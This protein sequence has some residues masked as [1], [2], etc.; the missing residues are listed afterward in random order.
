LPLFEISDEA[1]DRFCTDL[2]SYL[3]EFHNVHRYGRRGD[4]QD[5]IDAAG[6]RGNQH[7]GLQYR[8][9]RRFGPQAFLDTVADTT[10]E[11]D[12]YILTLASQASR[13][14][15]KA[16][17]STPNWE[18][19]DADD[20]AREVRRLPNTASRR[21]LDTYFGADWRRAF[22]GLQGPGAFHT[23]EDHFSPMMREGLLFDHRA[24]LVGR[25]EVI[26]GIKGITGA[27]N[28]SIVVLPGRGG[29]GKSRVLKAAAEAIVEEGWTVLFADENT[30]FDSNSLD[31]LPP[32]PCVVFVDDAHRRRDLGEL[33]S[34]VARR[35]NPTRLVLAIRPEGQAPIQAELRQSSVDVRLVTWHPQLRELSRD[36]GEELARLELGPDLARYARQLFAAT[37]DCTMVT[38]VGARLLRERR[39]PPGLL[40]RDQEF[41]D[42]VLAR[43]RDVVLGRVPDSVDQDLARRVLELVSALQPINPDAEAFRAAAATFVG[44]RMSELARTLDSLETAG[45]LVR[46][47]FSVRIVPDVLADYVL[48]NVCLTSRGEPTGFA[49]ELFS[50]F[51]AVSFDSLLANLG[52]VD[53]RIRSSSGSPTPLLD[54]IWT[55]FESRYREADNMERQRLMGMLRGVAAYQPERTL[56][57]AEWTVANPAVDGPDSGFVINRNE[58]VIW[59]LPKL[60]EDCAYGEHLG[61]AVELLW[62]LGR[63]DARPTNQFPDHPMRVLTRIGGYSPTTP[64]AVSEEV[65]SRAMRWLDDPVV[66]TYG[67]S[68]FDVIEHLLAKTGLDPVGD[69][70]QITYGH[71][72]VNPEVTRNLRRK[73]I[74]LAL[75]SL[76]TAHP[77]VA[78][79]AAR[80]LDE[81]LRDPIG[82]FGRQVGP[83]EKQRWEQ[84]Q[85]EILDGLLQA[86]GKITDPLVRLHVRDDVRWSARNGHSAAIRDAARAVWDAIDDD[87]ELRLT[88]ALIAPWSWD[89]DL[90]EALEAENL[91]AKTAA[92]IRTVAVE[93]AE[94]W[95]EGDD[96][97]ENIG[98]R[99]ESIHYAGEDAQ[100]GLIVAMACEGHVK[101]ATGV[102]QFILDRPGH[103]IETVFMAALR[104]LR[105][106]DETLAL[107]LAERAF[108]SRRRTLQIHV[109]SLYGPVPW[110]A[111][112]TARDLALMKAIQGMPNGGRAA[113]AGLELLAESDVAAAKSVLLAT[114]LSGDPNQAEE[115]AT[116]VEPGGSLYESLDERELDVLV[117]KFAPI[118]NIDGYHTQVMLASIAKRR[119]QS[120]TGMLLDRIDRAGDRTDLLRYHPLPFEVPGAPWWSDLPAEARKSALVIVRDRSLPA[121]PVRDALIPELF[122]WIGGDWGEEAVD[123]VMDWLES[124]E[125]NKVVAASGLVRE[126]PS[127]LAFNDPRLIER[128]LHA[129]GSIPAAR[130]R[131]RTA[132]L[133]AA[134]KAD[135]HRRVVL[136]QSADSRVADQAREAADRAPAGSAAREL[137][138]EI[139]DVADR[140]S[141][142]MRKVD[143]EL[144]GDAVD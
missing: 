66:H 55:A 144:L 92:R 11:A 57:L 95:S 129:T 120:V 39:I 78:V 2:A 97:A 51:G 90:D 20:I 64:L 28:L 19:W 140:R 96:F 100:P 75:R 43:F 80:L 33:L 70:R 114:D 69:G 121:T 54:N 62:R 103:I 31:E 142:H 26:R 61:R 101:L 132:L 6:D 106:M 89:F 35:A 68:P 48:G 13:D 109:A 110:T 3:P 44:V 125:E 88:R 30:P 84:E 77:K 76:V 126:A 87:S 82:F 15:R 137:Y 135:R 17:R 42:T 29:I 24:P 4:P 63:N 108:A 127:E 83:D 22:L 123:V 128:M 27:N 111:H 85:L 104:E 93:I 113:L 56:S 91:E 41:R 47:G 105:K 107:D 136:P 46:R 81:G 141:E 45:I 99:L 65:A 124:G 49:D 36:D 112:L 94:R 12:G 67:H 74:G 131:L 34:H 58:A 139:A 23:I 143:E 25:G 40:E 10:Y 37:H 8:R 53:W 50:A 115:L 14:L 118:D 73:I 1:F 86:V 130:S 138:I 16:A 9:V 5:G 52:E 21:L 72:Q 119:S 60:I 79:R 98:A 134:Y 116:L 59:M 38:V 32:E 122:G 7:V 71:I 18:L 117:A 102:A 133:T